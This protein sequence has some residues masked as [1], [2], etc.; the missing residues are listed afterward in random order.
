MTHAIRACS[1]VLAAAAVALVAAS[2]CGALIAGADTEGSAD[3]GD[4]SSPFMRSV[5]TG[6]RPRVR[7]DAA[8]GAD[9][10]GVGACP[11]PA[12]V[13]GFVPQ[14]KPPTGAHQ[15]R[16]P[17]SMIDEYYQNCL[18]IGTSA[19]CDA[20]GPAADAAHQ[21]CRRCLSR[22]FGDS[23]WGPVIEST[24]KVETNQ[25]GCIFLLDPSSLDCA[26]AVEAAAECEHAA[27]DPVCGAEN[28]TA[29]DDW[30]QCSATANACACQSLFAAADCVKQIAADAGAAA[31][32]LVG[33][34]FQDFFVVTAGLFC[35]P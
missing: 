34:T 14:W 8:A 15:G 6:P 1:A 3:S 28:A 22:N 13:S 10:C 7:Q 25:A 23:V 33:Q 21:A 5:T 27:C 32:C 30:I 17:P 2:G 18:A 24:N 29:F 9:S 26:K 12:D 16:C 11:L 35:G 19:G 4:D 31:P 20:F